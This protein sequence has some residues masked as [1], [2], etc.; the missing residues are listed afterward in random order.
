MEF[1]MVSLGLVILVVFFHSSIRATAEKSLKR[2]SRS[3]FPQG[4][5]F[6]VGS[7]AFQYEGAAT[8][9][10]RKP[11]IMDTFYHIPGKV[12]D[13]SNGD[14]AVDQYHRHKEDVDLMHQMGIDAYRFSISWSRLI[15]D[16]RGAVNPKGLEYYNNLIN[17]LIQNGIEPY[18]TLYHFDLP[19]SL[20]D[21]YG[22]WISP[23]IVDDFRAFT[24]VCFA[25]FG[26]RVKNW[27]TFNEPNFFSVAG[28]GA[29]TFPPARCS[30][31]LG[32][33][34]TGNSSVEP[35]IVGHNVLLSHA[36][37]VE[38]YRKRYQAKH[39]GSIGLTIVS[40]WYVPL[41][42]EPKDVTATQR[43]IDFQ[44]GW[45]LD[46]LI[47]GDYPARMK[48]RVASRLP[49]FTKKQSE[50]VH[51]SFDLIGLNHY[52]TSYVANLPSNEKDNLSTGN[53][54]NDLSVYVTVERNGIPI[55]N[56]TS[57]YGMPVVPWG[58][59][60]LLEYIK[61]HYNN[62]PVAVLEN[63]FAKP[64]NKSLPVEAILVDRDRINFHA[65]YIEYLLAAVSNGSDTRAYFIW[66][67]L[68][69][70]EIFTGYTW[71]TG[72]FYVDFDDNLKRYPRNSALWY[73]SFLRTDSLEL[74]G[75]T[76]DQPAMRII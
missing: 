1:K 41:T 32:N 46:P 39:T 69:D 24:N 35:Y 13:G 34:S 36:A 42:N 8:E 57:Y 11:S 4:F 27:M 20:Q 49:S 75:T 19:Q 22:G 73:K 14:I 40:P 61:Q 3:D 10:G 66:T 74:L 37:A 6:G 55:A 33:C 60:G 29:D 54:F 45:F 7:S 44:L 17:E 43:M 21:A 16:G 18:V 52:S 68:D 58:M 53:Y 48:E 23:Q 26:D 47:F 50:K 12:L 31:P 71:E 15:P 28:Y 25:E 5:V 72:L 64:K 30:F 67:L 2:L 62:P 56:K 63:G 70:F 65:E 9:D 59:Q 76:Q 38:L 51:G